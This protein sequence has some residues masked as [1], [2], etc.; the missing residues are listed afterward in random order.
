MIV[1]SIVI[2]SETREQARAALERLIQKLQGQEPSN[3]SSQEAP[4]TLV[5]D[6][7]VVAYSWREA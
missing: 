6:D 1:M 5:T 4:H 7:A 3:V 2:N